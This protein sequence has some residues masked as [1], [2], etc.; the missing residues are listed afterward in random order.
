MECDALPPSQAA[1]GLHCEP[2]AC[3][4]S[5]GALW[6]VLVNHSP[7]DELE[8]ELE[9]EQLRRTD[10][11]GGGLGESIFRIKTIS[12]ALNASACEH[13]MSVCE[14]IKANNTPVVSNLELFFISFQICLLEWPKITQQRG[15]GCSSAVLF[16]G[17]RPI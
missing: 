7:G 11:D 9:R 15:V 13:K 10:I 12:L 6:G 2:Q 16:P 8:P 4:Y 14:L 5:L 1:A 3:F 17:G